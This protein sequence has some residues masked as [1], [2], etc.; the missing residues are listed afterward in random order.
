MSDDTPETAEVHPI[1]QGIHLSISSIAAE[2]GMT[3]ET[4][5]RRIADSMLTPS[6]ETRG[7]PVYRLKQAL[8]VLLVL[9]PDGKPDPDR[10]EPVRRR[11]HYQAENEK[12]DLLRRQG[13]VIPKLEVEAEVARILKALV[14]G[15]DT[16]TDRIERD[17]GLSSGQLEAID[18]AVSEIRDEMHSALTAPEVGSVRTSA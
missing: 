15:L 2:F 9:G 6:G 1:A 17:C 11:M 14:Q 4:V 7:Y 12:L 3:R 18:K 10:M 5:S 13:E 16:L 8:Q